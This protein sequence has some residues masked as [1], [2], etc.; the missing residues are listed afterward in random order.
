MK[1]VATIVTDRKRYN[2]MSQPKQ[3]Q[4][5]GCRGWKGI[6]ASGTNLCTALGELCIDYPFHGWVEDETYVAP[7]EPE[8]V[9]PVAEQDLETF[10]W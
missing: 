10:D 1:A 5:A 8:Q 4:C 2:L 9:A 6:T 3:A 7:A